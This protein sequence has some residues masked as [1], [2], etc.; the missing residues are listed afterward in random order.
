MGS[1]SNL[2][3]LLVTIVVVT[4]VYVGIR[5]FGGKSVEGA[6]DQIRSELA[7][8]S[9]EAVTYCHQPVNLG[10]GGRSFLMFNGTKRTK[11]HTKRRR[12]ITGTRLWES[13]TAVYMVLVAAKDSVV[14][15]GKGDDIGTDNVNPIRV[16]GIVKPSR[17]YTIEK[18]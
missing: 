16:W 5:T 4:A 15:E 12:T 11:V 13:E 14:I 3:I 8:L 10:G 2:L 18:N 6:R 1:Q 7:F 9:K 17:F